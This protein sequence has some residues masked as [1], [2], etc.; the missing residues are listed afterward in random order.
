MSLRM[1]LATFALAL[2]CAGLLYAYG[3][4]TC[5]GGSGGSAGTLQCVGDCADE[6]FTCISTGVT[7]W[8]G[9]QQ[10]KTCGCTDGEEVVQSACCHFAWKAKE[11]SGWDPWKFGSCP[12]CPANGTCEL[13]SNEDNVHCA[14]TP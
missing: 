7:V 8:I 4:T 14:V 2:C 3:G 6:G 9:E 1:I 10:Y 12:P 11:P 13:N 5:S